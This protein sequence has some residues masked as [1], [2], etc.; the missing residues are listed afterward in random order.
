MC[1]LFCLHR[2]CVCP[3]S[4]LGAGFGAECRRWRGEATEIQLGQQQHHLASRCIAK[5][6]C[7]QWEYPRYSDSDLSGYLLELSLTFYR[8]QIE[9]S[10]MVSDLNGQ[11][12]IFRY[13]IFSNPKIS[14]RL[15]KILYLNDTYIV[16]SCHMCTLMFIACLIHN[17]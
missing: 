9:S 13:I 11:L 4:V 2:F 5:Q 14:L 1:F 15:R 3:Q 6:Q 17:K 8:D 12:Y 16:K 7:G 10:S